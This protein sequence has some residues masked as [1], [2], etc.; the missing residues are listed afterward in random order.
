MG[1]GVRD[2]ESRSPVCLPSTGP[3]RKANTP[4]PQPIQLTQASPS[5]L[6]TETPQTGLT[7]GSRP[8]PPPAPE[9]HGVGARCWGDQGHLPDS[10]VVGS[11]PLPFQTFWPE[12]L[13]THSPSPSRSPSACRPAP[14]PVH[15]LTQADTPPAS[16]RH[17]HSPRARGGGGARL[18]PG[19]AGLGSL[20]PHGR[21]PC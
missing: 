3:L 2:P 21:S 13:T 19:S 10:W 1:R 18:V 9:Q 14:H 11:S 16:P 15:A 8:Y 12:E 7:S 5:L 17:T 6:S 4:L 20:L